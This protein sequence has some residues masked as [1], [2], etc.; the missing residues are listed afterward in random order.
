MIEPEAISTLDE[1]LD[2]RCKVKKQKEKR[3]KKKKKKKGKMNLIELEEE[4]A[5]E[6]AAGN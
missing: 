4:L 2:K 3:E 1:I 6:E 5:A